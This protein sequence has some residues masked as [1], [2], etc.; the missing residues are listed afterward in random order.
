MTTS[1]SSDLG[2]RI[3]ERIRAADREIA[4]RWLERLKTLLPVDAIDIFPT[5]QI[6][7]HIPALIRELADYVASEHAEAASANTTMLSKAYELGELRFAQKASVHQLLREYRIL[8]AVLGQFVDEVCQSL[9]EAT[10][11]ADGI[12]ILNRLHEAVFVLLQMTVETFVTRY[13]ERI[14]DQTTRLEGFNRMVSHEL[15]QPLS[16]LQYALELLDRDDTAPEMRHQLIETSNRN[17]RRVAD[18]IRM[19]GALARPDRDSPQMQTVDLFKVTDEAIRQLADAA[20]AKEVALHNR[21]SDD[22]CT[23]DVSR[24]ELVL[25]NLIANGIK[26]RDPAKPERFV[27]VTFG[28]GADLIELRVRDN[29]LG[30]PKADL[31]KVFRRFYRGHA[32]RDAELDNDG[33]GLGLAIVAECVKGMRGSI[34][35]DSIE[36]EGTS[37]VVTLPVTPDDE[38]RPASV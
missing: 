10:A 3:A 9:P 35:V 5:D 30:I 28:A 38:T 27:E 17:V 29:G 12:V 34:T 20:A 25:V 13:T 23:V 18:L 7:D 24:L 6:L 19:L 32:A 1:L 4:S 31:P 14:E 11:P 37:F 33:V 8:G 16:A 26:Y 22:R 15:R 2:P 21:A 36:G